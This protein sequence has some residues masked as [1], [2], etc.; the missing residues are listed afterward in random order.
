MHLGLQRGNLTSVLLPLKWARERMKI[1]KP[2]N[3]GFIKPATPVSQTE[4]KWV[5][6]ARGR[7]SR[8]QVRPA[9][10]DALLEGEKAR[11]L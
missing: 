11:L 8:P 6:A 10:R 7:R 5:L 1:D 3:R 4:E 2:H 9:Q